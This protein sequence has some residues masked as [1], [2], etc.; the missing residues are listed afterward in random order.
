MPFYLKKGDLVSANVDVIVNASNVNLKMVEGVGRAIF[1][2]AGDSEL[3]KACKAIGKC[4]VGGAVMTPSFN[5]TNCKAIIHAVGPI[6]INGKHNEEP[7]L[8]KAY[9]NSLQICV[10]NGFK[11]VA[12]PLLSG[13]FNYPLD[14]AYKIAEDEF[15]KFLNDHKDFVIYMIIFKNFPDLLD[16][17]T[18]EELKNFVIE[19]FDA[20]SKDS[21]KSLNY[22][23]VKLVK[24]HM[25][26]KNISEN[27]LIE[28]SNVLPHVIN[29]LF[30]DAFFIPSKNLAL[31]IGVGLKLNEEDL[32]KLLSSIGYTDTKNSVVA[33]VVL[34]FVKEK[35]FDVY[36]INCALFTYEAKP[37]GLE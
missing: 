4:A 15:K 14:E 23:F 20:K 5:L 33:L 35:I 3:A 1:H 12:F 10:D 36:K 9:R 19:N 29:D 2:K 17:R 11:S 27:Q 32:I 31:A 22:D 7:L 18:H 30:T 21:V 34:F 24:E 25:Q 13:E 6:Y 26:N 28:D 16:D 37:L 8:R